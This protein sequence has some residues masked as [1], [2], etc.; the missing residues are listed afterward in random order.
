MHAS[1]HGGVRTRVR[2]SILKVETWRKVPCRTDLRQRRDGPTL[3]QLS[4]ILIPLLLSFLLLFV[5]LFV[6][7]FFF[8]FF[9]SLS[10]FLQLSD[11]C[12]GAL[13]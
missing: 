13:R 10:D 9:L 7:F 3:F 11:T 4:Y 12:S 5:C 1:A 2:E 6:D 8:F